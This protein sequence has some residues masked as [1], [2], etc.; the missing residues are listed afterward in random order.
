VETCLKVLGADFELANAIES[1]TTRNGDVGR[2]ARVLLREIDGLPRRESWYGTSIEWG[3]RFLPANGSSFYIDSDHLEVNLPEHARAGDHAAQVYAGLG[4][5]RDAQ[6]AANAK[7]GQGR[8]NV[9]CAV[10]DAKESWG[11]HLNVMVT[12]ELFDDVFMRKPHLLGFLATHPATATLFTGQGKVGAGNGREA[13]DYQLS[14]RADYFESLLGDQTMYHRPLINA[15]DESHAGDDLARMHLI[16]FDRVLCPTANLLM[17]GTTQL[18]LAMMEAGWCDPEVCLDNPLQSA[19]EVSRDLTLRR[20]LRLARR[21]RSMSAVEVQQALADLAG[22]F[23]S[24]GFAE[25]AVPEAAEVVRVWQQT[26]EMVRR[27]D[28]GGLMRHCDWALKLLLLDRMRGRKGLTWADAELK[29]LDMRYSSLDPEEGLFWQMAEAGQVDGMPSGAT[30][31]RCRNE[32]PVQTRA[33]LRAH[34]LRRFGDRVSEVAWGDV[35]FRLSADRSWYTSQAVLEMPDPSRFGR[36]ES[37][38][39]FARCPTLTDLIVAVGGEEALNAG[40]G[41][42]WKSQSSWSYSGY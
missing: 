19:H 31:E 25:D 7:L 16:Y 40:W 18:V 23:V 20:S 33:Y 9:T 24:G 6:T 11:H 32:P 21:G 22:E 12:R 26:L 29:T 8:V 41:R 39:L 17:A 5:A 15:R 28:L 38:E 34:L 3:R 1:E 36:D 27:R 13:C 37:E 4:V 30:I 35:R 14:Q 10:S 2:A 42:K